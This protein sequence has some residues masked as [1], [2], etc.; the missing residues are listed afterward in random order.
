MVLQILT[1]I[2]PWA[3]AFGSWI[4]G[5]GGWA[6]GITITLLVLLILGQLLVIW[7]LVDAISRKKLEN[8]V[9]WILMFLI[10]IIDIVFA[11]IYIIRVKKWFKK[12]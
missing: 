5:L 3:L 10:P 11:I 12:R 8:R 2:A 6:I 9:A 7:M 4:T 1:A